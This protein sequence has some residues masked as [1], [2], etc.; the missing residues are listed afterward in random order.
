MANISDIIENFIL[1]TMGQDNTIEISR[2]ALANYF[3]CAP[4]QIN[5]VL[6][7]RFT[8]DRGFSKESKRGGG[9][10]IKISKIDMQNDG[11]ALMILE[12]VGDELTSKRMNQILM[13]LRDEDILTDKELILIKTALSDEAL[14]VPII[15][16]DKL[17]AN[18]FKCVL[19]ELMK[20]QGER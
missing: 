12:N 16:K 4:S 5:Y 19:I 1:E 7:T 17:R 18:A 11:L 3:C 13:H 6:E 15:M 10:F 20:E 9:G 2:N 14:S 8:L